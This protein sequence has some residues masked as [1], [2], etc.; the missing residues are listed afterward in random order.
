MKPKKIKY[1]SSIGVAQ[2]HRKR[3]LHAF[4]LWFGIILVLGGI[5]FGCVKLI[6]AIVS[7]KAVAAELPKRERVKEA[8]VPRAERVK[9]DKGEHHWKLFGGKDD[10]ELI[11]MAA[12]EEEVAKLQCKRLNRTAIPKIDFR[13][14]SYS[15]LFCDLNEEQLEAA[16]ANGIHHAS[17]KT[18]MATSDELVHIEDNSL[19]VIDSLT[20][21]QPY[22][23]PKASLMLDFIGMRFQEVLKEKS[24]STHGY[25]IVV[26]SVLRSEEDNDKL[27]RYNRNATENSCHSYGTTIDI[28]Y[29]R[30]LRDDGEVVNELWLKE[31]LATALY[32][33][34]Y[35][36]I[37]YVK[38]EY[39]QGCFHITVRD[40][41]YRGNLA[42][43]YE[44]YELE[45]NETLLLKKGVNTN[46]IV[47]HEVDK[48]HPMVEI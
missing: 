27:R 47:K 45:D 19:Y 36:G 43:T 41:E 6:M 39:R 32:E 30:Y 18:T 3:A 17:S 26:T 24:H 10:D 35:E 4:I 46:H 44:K 48:V 40:T 20:Y 25:R 21:S 11:E 13:K 15:R 22:L 8:R 42:S 33:L 38:Y 31:A 16:M 12:E 5:G 1:K 23:V 29:I 9:K 28:S 14:V 2:Q 7:P 34:R 37:C